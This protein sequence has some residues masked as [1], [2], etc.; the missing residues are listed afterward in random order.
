M[1]A[2]VQGQPGQKYKRPPSQLIAGCSGARL[3]AQAM[4]EVEIRRIAM[5]GQ[6]LSYVCEPHFNRKKLGLVTCVCHSSNGGKPRV[7][8]L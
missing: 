3:S 2:V 7:G 8:V 4:Q 1:R 6:P 5:L